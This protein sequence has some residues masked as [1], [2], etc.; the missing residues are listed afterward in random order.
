VQASV[1]VAYSSTDG[2][3]QTF[4]RVTNSGSGNQNNPNNVS[5]AGTAP[6]I[7]RGLS[8][9]TASSIGV[10]LTFYLARKAKAAKQAKT[11]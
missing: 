11:L 3:V 8:L 6:Y 2:Y 4:Y 7:N 9:T 5:S 1:G 10:N